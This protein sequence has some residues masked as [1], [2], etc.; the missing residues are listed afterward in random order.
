MIVGNAKLDE[1]GEVH[2]Q[3]VMP[4]PRFVRYLITFKRQRDHDYR[5]HT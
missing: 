3:H 1:N 4:P 2:F 5:P